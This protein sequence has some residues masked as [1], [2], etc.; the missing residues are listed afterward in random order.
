MCVQNFMA[1]GQKTRLQWPK[2]H[3]KWLLWRHNVMT[4]LRR[5]NYFCFNWCISSICMFVP[6]FKAISRE[7]RPQWP[8]NR[9]NWHLWRHNVMTSLRCGILFFI[10]SCVS[11]ICKFLPNFKAIGPLTRLQWA[12][13][14][15]IWPE[16]RQNW[17]LWRHN[18]MTSLRRENIFA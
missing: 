4:S 3:P 1:I 9:P 14:C 16:N 18:V 6:N 8:K 12:N 2:N 11:I 17:H 7:T 15:Q 13:N 10:N 5:K